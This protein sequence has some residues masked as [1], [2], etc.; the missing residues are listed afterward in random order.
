[1]NNICESIILTFSSGHNLF[2]LK[3][4]IAKFQGVDLQTNKSNISYTSVFLESLLVT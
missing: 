2:T 1:M 4:R 3:L